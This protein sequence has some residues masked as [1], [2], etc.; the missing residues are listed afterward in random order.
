M[1]RK[2]YRDLSPA[3]NQCNHPKEGI[4][5]KG[6]GVIIWYQTKGQKRYLF[7]RGTNDMN[8]DAKW[9]FPKGHI[10]PFECPMCCAIRETREETGIVL[11]HEQLR[12]F[13]SGYSGYYYVKLQGEVR[14]T[15]QPEEITGY[16]WRTLEEQSK[17]S[18][19]SDL[20]RY[21]SKYSGR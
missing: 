21:I 18:N 2:H 20:R 16:S 12:G 7:L 8:G 6:Y 5:H 11:G 15:P 9:S 13:W 1:G 14:V 3:A 4:L 17:M 10:E 19:N